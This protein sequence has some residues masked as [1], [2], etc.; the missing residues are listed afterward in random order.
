MTAPKTCEHGKFGSFY[1]EIDEDSASYISETNPE[2]KRYVQIFIRFF[3][4]F[5]VFDSNCNYHRRVEY[6]TTATVAW[7]RGPLLHVSWCGNSKAVIGGLAKENDTKSLQVEL[8][9]Q[10]H[11]LDTPN[12]RRKKKQDFFVQK[13]MSIHL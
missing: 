3:F 9:T 8:L 12:E 2:D 1:L 13:L 11:T 4:C 5:F 10:P 7:K 6:G